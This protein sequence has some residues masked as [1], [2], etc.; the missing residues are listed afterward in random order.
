[1][2]GFDNFWSS[3][4]AIRT[5]SQRHAKHGIDIPR[6][7]GGWEIH[8]KKP[9]D[10]SDKPKRALSL[11]KRKKKQRTIDLPFNPK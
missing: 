7:E 1:M 9:L 5:H 6:P 11:V 3:E 8:S 2:P 10:L 4:D